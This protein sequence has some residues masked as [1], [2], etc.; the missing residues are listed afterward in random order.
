M[1]DEVFEA[2]RTVLAVREYQDAAV[3]EAVVFRILDAGRL[4]ASAGNQQPWHFVLVRDRDRLRELGGMVA[5]GPYIRQAA[6]AIVAARERTNRWSVSDLS[7]AIQSMIL[8]AWEAGVGS[9]VTAPGGPDAV[10]AY[11][12]LDERYEVLAVLPFGFPAHAAGGARKN[13]KPLA[14]VVS[15]EHAGTPLA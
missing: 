15:L 3:P 9:N 12:G 8:T 7:R 2:V 11:V 5:S 10:G 13:R 4:T 14:E 6:F 1:A